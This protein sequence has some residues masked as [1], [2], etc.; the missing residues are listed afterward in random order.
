MATRRLVNKQLQKYSYPSFAGLIGVIAG[1]HWYPPLDGNRL[2]GWGA[3]LL[4]LPVVGHVIYAVQKRLA[5]NAEQL[6][7]LYLGCGIALVLMALYTIANGALDNSQVQT[8][9]TVVIRKNIYSGKS[10]TTHVVWVPS[11]RP[12]KNEER[13]VVNRDV[14]GTLW[15][16]EAIVVDVHPGAFGMPWYTRVAPFG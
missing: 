4:F 2:A 15:V 6:K 1:T 14:Y 8:V 7:K 5:E 12:G 10:S 9:S 3:C 11:W 13:L 16:G